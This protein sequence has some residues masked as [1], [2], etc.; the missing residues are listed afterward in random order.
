MSRLLRVMQCLSRIEEGENLGT[1]IFVFFLGL[2]RVNVIKF[3]SGTEG[4]MV[5]V[6]GCFDR[7]GLFPSRIRLCS[8][9][10]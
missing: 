7:S 1:A 8:G 5:K 4:L 9:S 10:S 6:R 2:F 3:T